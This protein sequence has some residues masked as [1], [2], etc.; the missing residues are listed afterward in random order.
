M[1]MVFEK[2]NRFR[3][4]NMQTYARWI[5]AG[6]PLTVSTRRAG[7]IIWAL[8]SPDVGRMLCDEIDWTESQHARWL[9]DILIRTLLPGEDQQDRGG[10]YSGPAHRS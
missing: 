2:M 3:M 8:A 1:A 10:P 9:A 4:N 6:G 5:A 7:E